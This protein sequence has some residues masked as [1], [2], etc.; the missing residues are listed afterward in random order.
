MRI[1]GYNGTHT[2]TT[3]LILY[4]GCL[5]WGIPRDGYLN[6]SNTENHKPWSFECWALYFQT[7]ETSAHSGMD[8]CCERYCFASCC[9]KERD[10]S[11]PMFTP[12]HEGQSKS[13]LNKWAKSLLELQ[14]KVSIQNLKELCFAFF[15]KHHCREMFINPVG[16]LGVRVGEVWHGVTDFYHHKDIHWHPSCLRPAC[17]Q[18]SKNVCWNQWDIEDIQG[19]NIAIHIYVFRIFRDY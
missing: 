17:L 2:Y 13:V 8:D 15:F 12:G 19:L 4:L 11:S 18:M 1:R 9:W 14:A 16:C 5:K 6:S 7:I 10:V 3:N